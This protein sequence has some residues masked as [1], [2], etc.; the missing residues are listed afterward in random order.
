MS[1]PQPPRPAAPVPASAMGRALHA[2]TAL[3]PALGEG[4]HELNLTADHRDDAVV[5][6]SLNVTVTAESVRVDHPADEYMRFFTVLT[7]A[8]EQ[9]TV[10]DATLIA[11]TSADR[12]R[13]CGWEVRQGWLHPIDPADLQSAV[14]AHLTADDAAS[15]VICAAPVLHLPH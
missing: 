8:L 7:F 4:S 10:H 14:T 3:F 5:T 11:A 1:E 2:L 12:P 13:A 9:S 15:L 6:I